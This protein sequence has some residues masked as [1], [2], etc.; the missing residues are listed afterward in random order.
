ML[1]MLAKAVAEDP[2]LPDRLQQ[3]VGQSLSVD[4]QV[5]GSRIEF[6]ELNL[7]MAGIRQMRPYPSVSY[8]SDCVLQ[9]A[10]MAY[11]FRWRNALL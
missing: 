9:R 2:P 4:V 6:Q 10:N 11:T 3:R 5:Q 7:A 1:E 8:G